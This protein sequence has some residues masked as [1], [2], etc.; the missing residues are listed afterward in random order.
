MKSA[1]IVLLCVAGIAHADP[2]PPPR[3]PDDPIGERLFPPELIMSHQ[4]ELALD[5][6]TRTV[7]IDDIQKF[8]TVVVKLQW[9]LRRE[10]EALAKLLAADRPD[11]GNVLAQADKV[12]ALERDVKRAHLGLLVRLKA[13]LTPAQQ[14]T[15]QKVRR[16][17]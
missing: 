13:R 15:L 6:K 1:L 11:E 14:A 5:D 12:M 8:Q 7:M 2:T 10:G 4:R 9:D 17:P 3:P 16:A